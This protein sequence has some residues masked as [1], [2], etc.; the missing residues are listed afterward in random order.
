MLL[1]ASRPSQVGQVANRSRSASR[2]GFAWDSS[3]HSG[4]KEGAPEEP[5]LDRH[6]HVCSI[7][8]LL[9]EGVVAEGAAERRLQ[10]PGEP[11][12]PSHGLEELVGEVDLIDL[13]EPGRRNELGLDSVRRDRSRAQA[14]RP[15]LIPPG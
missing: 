1:L 4:N 8:E 14:D 3:G 5:C 7:R 11:E 2:N 6:H 9:V 15:S 10:L 12:P 13:D